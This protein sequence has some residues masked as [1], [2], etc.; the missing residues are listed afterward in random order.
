MLYSYFSVESDEALANSLRIA[1]VETCCL[2]EWELLSF[3]DCILDFFTSQWDF[4]SHSILCILN[5]FW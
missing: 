3:V 5:I 2:L 1:N 4:A